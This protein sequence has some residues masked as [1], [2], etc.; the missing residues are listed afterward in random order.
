MA[1]GNDGSRTYSYTTYTET[2][3]IEEAILK[4]SNGSLNPSEIY[5]QIPEQLKKVIDTIAMQ[6]FSKQFLVLSST[7]QQ[8]VLKMLL[9]E[10]E[11]EKE[12]SNKSLTILDALKM[13]K[14]GSI[15]DLKFYQSL[16]PEIREVFDTVS[17]SYNASNFTELKPE[18]RKVILEFII[19]MLL[20]SA[21]GNSK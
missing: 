17:M 20:K 2:Y 12:Q 8:E 10:I 15:D 4:A 11:K 3:T 19:E 14:E 1:S 5:R 13:A 9:S 18:L 6:V 7:Q 21:D 16:P